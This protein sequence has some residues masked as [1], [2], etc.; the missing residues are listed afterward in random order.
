MQRKLV[1]Q[2]LTIKNSMKENNKN[3]NQDRMD[4]N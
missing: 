2:V 4:E 3:A 1:Y